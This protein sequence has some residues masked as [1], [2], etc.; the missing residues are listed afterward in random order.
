M[1]N[2]YLEESIESLLDESADNRA[3]ALEFIEAYF[4]MNF[5]KEDLLELLIRGQIHANEDKRTN[6]YFER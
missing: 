3:E 1:K 6:S 4:K 5:T 2:Y